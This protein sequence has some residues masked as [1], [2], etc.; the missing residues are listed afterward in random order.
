[1]I[2]VGFD[3]GWYVNNQAKRNMKKKKEGREKD[4]PLATEIGEKENTKCD[5]FI[6]DKCVLGKETLRKKAAKQVARSF[7]KTE[8]RREELLPEKM[9]K[10][11]RAVEGGLEVY[12]KYS[13][14]TL[15]LVDIRPGFAP[16][17][18]VQLKRWA[19]T[20]GDAKE[21]IVRLSPSRAKKPIH[22]RD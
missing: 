22:A 1:V 12:V 6:E 17:L 4:V 18:N 2:S 21:K 3:A 16:I 7:A 10:Q 9:Q 13:K 19:A 8:E 14:K 15:I 11:Q 5:P 20:G